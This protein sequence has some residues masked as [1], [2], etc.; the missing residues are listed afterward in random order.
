M[1]IRLRKIQA[2]IKKPASLTGLAG[3]HE[4]VKVGKG[5]NLTG[6]RSGS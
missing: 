2:A 5:R 4:E 3:T 1:H 6:L